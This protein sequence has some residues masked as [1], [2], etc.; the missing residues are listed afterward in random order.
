MSLNTTYT[1]SVQTFSITLGGSSEVMLAEDPT[2]QS[3]FIQPQS[4]ACNIQF[5]AGAGT[6]ATGS[7]T[8]GTNPANTDT[9]A[10]NSQTFTFVTGA[11]TT[12]NVHIGATKEDTMANF[13]AVLQASVITAVGVAT[14]VAT[15]ATVIG[16]TYNATGTVGNA[17]TLADSTGSKIT[18]SGATLSGGSNTVGGIYLAQYQIFDGS[19]FPYGSIKDAVYVV[20]GTTAD[21]IAYLIG[22]G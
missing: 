1:P 20:A 12:T 11:S 18:A 17:F 6:A 9:I 5:G 19:A 16:L 10:V 13:L 2:R 3:L 14:Y 21:K 22:R 15:S 7:L 4:G 8:I